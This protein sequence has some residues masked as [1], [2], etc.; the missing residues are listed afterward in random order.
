MSIHGVPIRI[1]SVGEAKDACGLRELLGTEDSGQFHI[2]HVED[3]DL[4]AERLSHDRVDI[5]VVQQGSKHR[6][7]R[8]YVQA[9]RAAAPDTPVVVL[10]ECEDELLTIDALRQGVQDVLDKQ[11]LDRHTL[12]RALRPSIECHRLQKN[13]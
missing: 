10:A 12:M 7:G 13:L 8:A 1:L 3:L 5:F 11:H 6:Q 9:V 4:A 2:G